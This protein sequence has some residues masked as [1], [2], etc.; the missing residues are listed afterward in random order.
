MTGNVLWLA[1]AVPVEVGREPSRTRRCGS[2]PVTNAPVWQ[3]LA[4]MAAAEQI[5]PLGAV[6]S[7]PAIVL[8]AWLN[9]RYIG[10]LYEVFGSKPDSFVTSFNRW[11]GSIFLLL[12][13]LASVVSGL[14][15]LR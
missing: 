9:F 8:L 14:W 4:L 7:G 5:S 1:V 12:I 10:R 11:V 2:P 6:L 3:T 13:G 15:R